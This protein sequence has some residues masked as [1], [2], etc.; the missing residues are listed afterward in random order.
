KENDNDE[1]NNETQKENDNDEC[2][3]ET[4]KEN[5]NDECN[6]EDNEEE[7]EIPSAKKIRKKEI[8]TKD[9]AINKIKLKK[10][11]FKI[12]FNNSD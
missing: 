3:N 2:N 7:I 4:Q 5:D 10:R 1:C 9:E 6:E 12:K 8:L 11:E